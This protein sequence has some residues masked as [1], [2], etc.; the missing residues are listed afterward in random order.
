MTKTLNGL[1]KLLQNHPQAKIS[2]EAT[3]AADLTICSEDLKGV[4]AKE[5]F[6]IINFKY[7]VLD[8]Q[9]AD[10]NYLNYEL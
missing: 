9:T 7:I 2:D 8:T 4:V 6:V 10:P 5:E 1:A 3:E